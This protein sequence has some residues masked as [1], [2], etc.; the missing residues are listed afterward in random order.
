MNYGLI[1]KI[2]LDE[3]ECL[4]LG[5]FSDEQVDYFNDLNKPHQE[6]VD[7]LIPTLKSPG[8]CAWQS[9]IDG[10]RLLLVHCGTKDKFN[11]ENLVKRITEITTNLKKQYITSATIAL[12]LIAQV[13][14]NWQLKQMILQFD[15]QLYEFL[16]F[17]TKDRQ[18][19]SLQL[20]QFCSPKG[21]LSTIEEANSVAQGVRLARNLAN[22]PANICTPEHLAQQAIQLEKEHDQL[23]TK[24][25]LV[26]EL[27]DMGM[28]A[29]LAVGQG[30][31]QEPRLIQ[32]TYNGKKDA[33]PIVLVG[34]GITFDSGGISIK[35]ALSM[36]EM[37]YDMAGAASVMGVLKACALLQLPINVVGLMAC[38]ENMPSGSAVKP[39]DVVKSMSGQTIEIIN[40]DAE[41]RLVLAD[42]LTYAHRFSPQF[43]LDIA[44][45]TGAMVIAL[46]HALTGFMTK[47]EELGQLILKA[48]EE[49]LDKSWR[50][51]LYEGYQESIESPVADMANVSSDRTAGAITAACFLS[52]F[53]QQ[54]RWAHLDIAG[55]A[56]VSGKKRNATGRPVPL[57][58]QFLQNI[59]NAS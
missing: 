37:K 34:K 19:S 40:T 44:T 8:D 50:M 38:A 47:D 39:G 48:S 7:R 51:P 36:E 23:S 13:D 9:D 46:G 56:W 35:P 4:V 14:P 27:R 32:M 49:S 55:T 58:I 42:T 43:V 12:P 25:M 31:K 5:F 29:F 30:S 59:A 2:S 20:I 33:S 28:E 3:N 17:K 6:L 18:S 54:F 11:A 24:I 21:L 52:R 26:D 22:L 57:L 16:D 15:Y 1:E 41:G 45:L 53:T 10:K